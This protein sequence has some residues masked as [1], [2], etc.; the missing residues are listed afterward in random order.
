MVMRFFSGFMKTIHS[1]ALLCLALAAS[2]CAGEFSHEAEA[3]YNVSGGARTN[4]GRRNAD[5]S[6]QN[7]DF[8]Y[9]LSYTLPDRPIVRFGVAYDRY[10]FS[11]TRPGLVP[12]VLQSLSLVAGLDLQ[13]SD[14]LIRIE[15]QPGFYGSNDGFDS[16]DFNVPILLGG[17]YLVSKDFQWI[18]GLRIDP[19]SNYPVMGGIGFRW[20]MADRW[21]L[22]LAPP[23]P[24]LE[25]KA[26]DDVT[27]YAGGQLVG[28]TF[29][30][31]KNF[32][33]GRRFSRYS[34][35]IV[36]YT[37]IRTGAGVSWKFNGK[38]T[39]NLELGYM[40]YRDFDYHRVGDNFES[41]GGSI[42]GQAGIKVGF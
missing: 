34:D 37:E 24:R 28:S 25:Y 14:V 40:A 35:A 3:S 17:S 4:L 12:G 26:T 27:L 32:D 19:N 31:S 5:V 30:V 15:A 2:A 13:V 6:E 41:K 22:N 42:Y 9:V 1:S 20:K 23:N 10:Y 39:L 11:Y 33:G 18:A 29:R 8:Q 36:D 38:G 16:R 7:S 21:V